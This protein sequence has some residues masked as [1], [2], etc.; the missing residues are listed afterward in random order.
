MTTSLGFG[1]IAIAMAVVAFAYVMLEPDLIKLRSEQM[2]AED[3]AA[4]GEEADESTPVFDAINGLLDRLGWKGFS[5]EQLVEAGIK[6]ARNSMI[7]IALLVAIG[8]TLVVQVLTSNLFLGL[9]AG[10]AGIF[11]TKAY[12]TRRTN[13]RKEK[14][15]KQMSETMT[16][17]S[18]ALKSGMNVPTAMA[19]TA[20]EMEAPMGEELARVV[21]ESR[22]GRDIVVAMR[23]TADRMDSPDFLW[24]TEAIAIQRESGGR[25]SEILDR[26]T[27]T[28]AERNE[29]Q[30]KIHSLAAEGRA[31][32]AILM[33]LPV[34]I[35]LLFTV[36]NPEFM[37]PLYTTTT[38]YILI[39]VAAVFYAIGGTWLN[40]I[41]KVKL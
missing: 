6:V 40:M 36:M 22:L 41:T 28:I 27:D 5:E 2:R 10:I 16:L 18:S 15:N 7:A 30:Q 19:S 12:V 14:F 31:S 26:V 32:A 37:A 11:G 1:I 34:G 8:A 4:N 33:A 21:N 24:V 13:K 17:L 3:K 9:I 20:T 39:G 38:G 29:L 25:L 23:E 35:G